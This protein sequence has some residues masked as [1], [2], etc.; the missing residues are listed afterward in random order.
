M[1]WIDDVVRVSSFGRRTM[2]FG[3]PYLMHLSRLQSYTSLKLTRQMCYDQIERY[4]ERF[5]RADGELL[6]TN[7]VSSETLDRLNPATTPAQF[8]LRW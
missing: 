2:I 5:V 8:F 7:F 4:C 1:R 3:L 6:C